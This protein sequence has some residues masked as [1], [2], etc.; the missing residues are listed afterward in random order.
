MMHDTS[1]AKSEDGKIVH[2]QR[3]IN[4]SRPF[5][6]PACMQ[7]MYAATEGSVQ[8]PHFRHKNGYCSNSESYLHIVAKELFKMVFSSNTSFY[9]EIPYIA[10]CIRTGK[11]VRKSIETIDLK[12]YF[13]KIDI[14]SSDGQW[15]PDCMLSNE[16]GEKLFVEICHT[17]RVTDEKI[18]TGIPIVEII[19]ESEEDLERLASSNLL[20]KDNVRYRVYNMQKFIRE[21]HF[22]C[23]GQCVQINRNVVR[24]KR[25]FKKIGTGDPY[26]S[27]IYKEFAQWS[28]RIMKRSGSDV[29][30]IVARLQEKIHPKKTVRQK[31]NDDKDEGMKQLTFDL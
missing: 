29:D 8:R 7:E 23:D 21:P 28:N 15:R 31:D 16:S 13:S 4:R 27:F 6:C 30:D 2:A 25:H 26:W 11:C 3:G 24:S 22:H 17:H 1:F 5:Y 14:E 20:R 12:Y 10:T 19:V 18:A 9:L